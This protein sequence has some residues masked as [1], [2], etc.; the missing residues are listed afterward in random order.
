MTI[1]A[2]SGHQDIPSS[3]EDFVRAGVLAVLQRYEGEVVGTCALAA[4]ADQIFASAVLETGGALHVVIPSARYD[5]TF[6]ESDRRQYERLLARATNV[7]LLP[8]EEPSEDAFLAAGLR[9]VDGA[10]V[11]VAIWDGR[12]ARGRGGT[13]DVVDYARSNGT[14]VVIVWPTGVRRSE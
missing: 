11:L 9:L 13:G 7:E 14:S 10:D 6:A 4:G 3:A 2:C 12:Q 5:E 1:I 8:F